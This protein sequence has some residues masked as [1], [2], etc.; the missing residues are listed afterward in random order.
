MN[1]RI[2]NYKDLLEEKARLEFLLAQQKQEFR[3]N[4]QTLK[5]DYSP[6]IKLG[7][8]IGMLTTRN[9]KY[10]LLNIAA[11]MLITSLVKNKLL[12]RAGWLTRLLVP[13]FMKNVSSHV[14]KKR[15]KQLFSKIRDLTSQN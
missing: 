9:Y 15:A 14:I 8:A 3:S 1:N 10:P 12:A 7:S 13:F 5:E 4:L 6:L 11:G 2:R